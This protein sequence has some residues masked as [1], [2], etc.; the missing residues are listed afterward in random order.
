M[1]S[2]GRGGVGIGTF[3]Y[4]CMRLVKG[5]SLFLSHTLQQPASYTYMHVQIEKS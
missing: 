4:K 2:Q 1:P 5:C 3:I